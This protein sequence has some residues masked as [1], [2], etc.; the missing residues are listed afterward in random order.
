MVKCEAARVIHPVRPTRWCAG[1]GLPWKGY[2][3]ALLYRKYP[4]LYRRRI[5]PGVPWRYYVLLLTLLVA[6]ALA[7]CSHYLAAWVAV[8][9]WAAR[10]LGLCVRRLRGTTLAPSHVAE[11]ALTSALIPL[12]SIYWRLRG[13]V[14][15][16]V[17]FL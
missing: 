13:A 11:M 3:D 4:Q 8:A 2:F 7:L 6:G 16:R 1:L 15:F 12:L 17:F 5:R 14:K 10:T 9:A